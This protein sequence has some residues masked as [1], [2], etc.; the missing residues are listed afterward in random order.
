MYSL[1][2]Q[3]RNLF[4]QYVTDSLVEEFNC[5]HLQAKEMVSESALIEVLDEMPDFVLHYSVSHWAKQVI[6]ENSPVC[7]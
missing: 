7:V 1:T 4:L 3:D 5:D 6:E 2:T